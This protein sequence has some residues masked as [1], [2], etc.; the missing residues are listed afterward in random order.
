MAIVRK[1]LGMLRR[2]EGVA[3]LEFAIIAPA[4]VIILFG[5]IEV[6]D[7]LGAN[8]GNENVAAS[9]ADVVSRDTELDDTE[10]ADV[11]QAAKT[12]M[13]PRATTGL[14]MRLTSIQI[15]DSKTTKVLWTESY[16][17]YEKATAVTLPAGLMQPGTT[18]IQG[19]ARFSYKPLLGMIFKTNMKLQ[20]TE[21]R[22]PRMQDQV[23]RKV[24]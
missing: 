11:W 20:H 12:L 2:R 13:F 21:Y 18:L 8:R 9:I 5:A 15:V 16:G 3:A 4:L 1:L 22:R 7:L 19:D 17:G 10:L 14:Q 6:T 24:G 23:D